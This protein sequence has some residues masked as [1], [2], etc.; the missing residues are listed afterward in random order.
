MV[1]TLASVAEFSAT[2]RGYLASASRVHGSTWSARFFTD[3]VNSFFPGFTVLALS[4]LAAGVA[5]T[6]G[7]SHL[8]VGMLLLLAGVGF[9]LSLGTATPVYGWLFHVFPPMQGLRAAARFGYLFLLGMAALAGLGLAGVRTRL[10]P[11]AGLIVGIVLVALAN[12]ESLRAP[13]Q[14]TRFE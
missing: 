12:L 1:R 6:L 14:Y 3:D 7:A 2:P 9:V 10:S 11:R 4:L 5:G 8:R 13:F